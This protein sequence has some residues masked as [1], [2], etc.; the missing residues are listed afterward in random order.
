[1]SYNICKLLN[2]YHS[3]SSEYMDAALPFVSLILHEHVVLLVL[4]IRRL[5]LCML[6]CVCVR[7]F[8]RYGRCL[9]NSH[10]MYQ[11]TLADT[12]EFQFSIDLRTSTISI[13]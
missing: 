7:N 3:S 2:G 13:N 11:S 6:I 12:F 8:K 4:R 10:D 5:L 9:I 1:M